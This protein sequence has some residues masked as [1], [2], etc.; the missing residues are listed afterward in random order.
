[1]E[2]PEWAKSQ[3]R[4]G[5]IKLHKEDGEILGAT[6]FSMTKQYEAK[7]GDKIVLGKHGLVVIAGEKNEK[8]AVKNE[9]TVQ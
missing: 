9:N 5:R 2:L 8:K 7:I 1:M 6:V 4:Q 3:C